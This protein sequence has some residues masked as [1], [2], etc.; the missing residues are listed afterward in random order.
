MLIEHFF[1]RK[2]TRKYPIIRNARGKSARRQCFE[3]FEDYT[4]EE[5][6]IILAD[7]EKLVGI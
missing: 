2:K 4:D 6:E 3:L 5:E 7:I 1:R